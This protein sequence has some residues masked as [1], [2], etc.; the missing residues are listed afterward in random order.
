MLSRCDRFLICNEIPPSVKQQGLGEASL[1]RRV[2]PLL[3]GCGRKPRDSLD[4]NTL[5]GEGEKRVHCSSQEDLFAKSTPSSKGQLTPKAAGFTSQLV[6]QLH[7]IDTLR[8]KDH[9][10]QTSD[11]RSSV[12]MFTLPESGL[13][14]GVRAEIS[15]GLIHID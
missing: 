1:R 11:I 3:E 9:I 13:F 6:V 4:R 8:A 15:Q 2:C 7:D 10:P 14:R 12:N 5:Y